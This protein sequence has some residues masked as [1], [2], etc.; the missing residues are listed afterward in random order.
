[1]E[2]HLPFKPRDYQLP[3][4]DA[5]INKG[6]K[7]VL[8]IMP[9]RAGKDICAF[10]ILIIKA[11]QE[12]GYYLYIFPFAA[13]ARKVIYDA[14]TNDGT[15]FLDY[16]PKELIAKKNSTEMKI[17][18]RNGSII[19]LAGSDNIDSLMGLNA[20]GI[21]YSEYALQS[22][23]AYSM[24]RPILVV[25]GGWCLMVSTPRGRNHM[26]EL[27][28]I[29]M[30]SKDWFVYKLTLDDTKH[31]S[32]EDIARE[33]EEGIMS[34]SLIQQEYYT[35][36]DRGISGSVYD[37]Y[38]QQ[39]RFDGRIGDVPYDTSLPVHTAWDLGIKDPTI[40]LLWQLTNTGAIKIINVVEKS[41]SGFDYFAKVLQ[42]MGYV[43]GRHIAPFD[44]KVRELGTG[45]S[46]IDRARDLGI[47]FVVP[48][49][50]DHRVSF[51]DGIVAV[52]SIFSRLYIDE[53]KCKRFIKALETYHY[54]Y[55]EK[56]DQYSRDPVHDWSSH[57][58]DAL[59]YLALSLRKVQRGMTADDVDRVL[60]RHVYG[61][62]TYLPEQL[63]PPNFY[64]GTRVF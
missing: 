62:D 47:D 7:R 50:T 37:R 22:P 2:I 25:S 15:T 35:S 48:N 39:A 30:K 32:Q 5:I 12:V 26:W 21:I 51:D 3:I 17:T 29:A 56:Y 38:V 36:W 11:L 20:K 24:L 57:Y 23:L 31:I 41:D 28:N 9:R 52:Q 55:D 6:Y 61:A 34:D 4:M 49:E 19:Q 33:V 54:K 58:C 14:I 10:N 45:M 64:D 42:D 46:R 16:I 44:I 1:M 43:Y 13:Q 27:Y 8:C 40:I 18:L 63:R 59:R 53:R 60:G